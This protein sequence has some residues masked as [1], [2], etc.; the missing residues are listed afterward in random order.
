MQLHVTI[1]LM[2]T[3]D[4]GSCDIPAAG[5]DCD[6]N[7]LSGTAVSLSNVGLYPSEISFT[8][9]DC[10]GNELAAGAAGYSE[11][12]DLPE[13]Y[14]VNMS[15]SWGDG[16]GADAL[17]IG[18]M[19]YTMADGSSET[20]IVGSC[21][22]LGCTDSSA[23]NYNMDA[24]I[25]D[26]TCFSAAA[27][28]DCDGNCLAANSVVATLNMF[29]SW[30]DGWS[31]A[32]VTVTDN[33]TVVLDGASLA[34][35]SEGSVDFCVS[36]GVT[37]G[38]SCIE[39][40]V[41]SDFYDSEVSWTITIL[42]GAFTVLSGGSNASFE[43]GCAIEGCMDSAACNYNMDATVSSDNCEY[44]PANFDCDGQCT[45]IEFVIDMYDLSGNADGWNG[46]TFQVTDW[47]TGEPVEGAGPFTFDEGE[48]GTADA[49][50]PAD[51]AWG[52]Y[53]MEI[54]GGEDESQVGW[55]LYGFEV[56]GLYVVDWSAGL[57]VEWSEVGGELLVGDGG[58]DCDEAD[59]F[60]EGQA[61]WDSGIG[62]YDTNGDGAADGYD[63]GYGCPC[64]DP[65][66]SNYVFN[67]SFDDPYGELSPNV[68][69]PETGLWENDGDD[70]DPCEFDTDVP[71]CM[72]STAT[73]YDAMATVDDGTCEYESGCVGSGVDQDALVASLVAAVSQGAVTV[74]GC[75][76]GLPTLN[77]LLGVECSTDM[78]VYTTELPAGTTAGDLC[79]CSCPDPI[80]EGCTDP[81]AVNYNADANTD[82]GS[83]CMGTGV[84]QDAL[85]AS[86]VAAVCKVLLQLMAVQMVYQ[87]LMVYSRMFNRYV[88]LYN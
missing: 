56:F 28:F 73:N 19:S 36:D 3:F 11:C 18:D 2:Q 87:H 9:T 79:G 23:C 41:T 76:D 38:S 1:M 61:D 77:G 12:L 45:G 40:T 13:N 26:G 42:D 72:D 22:V 4:D 57:A 63:I 68:F 29:D 15:D 66:G 64:L 52:C 83:C 65:D 55:H 44:P 49:C 32:A 31:G 58:S 74:N 8:I 47:V 39:V 67:G 75:A 10:D 33:G 37:A 16:W 5:F 51:M 48:M 21:G 6:G 59:G 80:V 86:L 46:N 88:S 71:G 82:D 35:G 60:C 30:G 25:D 27:G 84:D 78:S 17:T 43:A 34:V 7:C 85:V 70:S 62:T 24:T 69:N 50:F 81:M 53:V 14:S 20:V 54:G